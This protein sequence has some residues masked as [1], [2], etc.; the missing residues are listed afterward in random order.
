VRP[1]GAGLSGDEADEMEAG[2]GNKKAHG[3]RAVTLPQ[4]LL[5]LLGCATTAPPDPAR[6]R[7][8]QSGTHWNLVREDAV[9]EDLR[10]AYPEFFEV[11]L[12]PAQ[13]HLPDLRPLR[14]DLERIPVGRRNFD[15]LNALAIGYF[16]TNYRAE[17][18]RGEGLGYLALSQ[19]AAKLLAVPWRA[20]GET[21]DGKLRDAII[22]F[23]EDA[24]TGEKLHASDTA[25]R[26]TRIVASLERKEQDPNR[27]IRIREL[28]LRIEAASSPS[29]EETR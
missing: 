27:R 10:P 8:A 24:G 4:I 23:F 6:Y 28:A 1:A 12:D 7:L 17:V 15:A 3:R 13:V 26:L 19:R 18:G 5:L 21:G 29:L 2:V 20:Y 25:P 14:D 22:D 16:E 9:F 11:I